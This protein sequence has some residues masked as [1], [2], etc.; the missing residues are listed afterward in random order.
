MDRDGHQITV[1]CVNAPGTHPVIGYRADEVSVR[2]YRTDGRY[3]TSGG[4]PSRMDLVAHAEMV[5]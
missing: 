2:T 4:A 5:R 3:Y 1:V